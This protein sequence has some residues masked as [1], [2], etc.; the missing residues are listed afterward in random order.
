MR[1][2]TRAHCARCGDVVSRHSRLCRAC[3]RSASMVRRGVSRQPAEVYRPSR[4][5][6][7]AVEQRLAALAAAR[8]RPGAGLRLSADDIWSGSGTLAHG[9]DCRVLATA[10][11]AR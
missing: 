4:R 7:V 2:K 9:D 3:A 11:W 1:K 8:R 6:L 10:A 5:E